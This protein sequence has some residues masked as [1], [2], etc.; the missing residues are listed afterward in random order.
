MIAVSLSRPFF[1]NWTLSSS[2]K[3]VLFLG[4][5]STSS[6]AVVTTISKPPAEAEKTLKNATQKAIEPL[7]PFAQ[8]LGGGTLKLFN[9]L[10]DWSKLS[11]N[12][13]KAIVKWIPKGIASGNVPEGAKSL[14]STL[15]KWSESIFSMAKSFAP[16]LIKKETY[17]AIRDGIKSSAPLVKNILSIFSSLFNANLNGNTPL[18]ST[19]FKAMDKNGFGD[20]MSLFSNFATMQQQVF[21][22]MTTQDVGDLFN[23]FSVNQEG[24]RKLLESVTNMPEGTAKKEQLMEPIKPASLAGRIQDA[25][26]RA[27]F[28]LSKQ[29]LE[30]EQEKKE[31]IAAQT[32]LQR[33]YQELNVT[34]QK[35]VE[36]IK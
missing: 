5:A 34:I 24:T 1:N 12:V 27:Q 3:P 19:L 15:S 18:I 7:L 30:N 2:L 20:F 10:G 29:K 16:S 36:K 13:G 33:L 8:R 6:I 11:S 31:A 21:S 9:T 35:A 28:F 4:V 32:E 17:T 22:Q 26:A 25:I 23:A 14:F